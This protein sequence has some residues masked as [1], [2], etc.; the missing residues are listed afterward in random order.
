MK[1]IYSVILLLSFLVGAFQPIL[2]MI[3]FQLHHGSIASLMDV[4]AAGEVSDMPTLS[5][6][7]ETDDGAKRQERSL[8]DDDF[9]PIAVQIATVPEP[10]HFPNKV[11][12]YLPVIRNV[13]GPAYLPNPP[14]PRWS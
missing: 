1:K 10:F 6:E 11:K 9:Y 2:P 4:E 12:L 8:L 14:P 7:T 5:E 13:T 3:E